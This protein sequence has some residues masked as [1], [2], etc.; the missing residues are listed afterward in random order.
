M[1]QISRSNRAE[2]FIAE[3][4]KEYGARSDF[5][6]GQKLTVKEVK[7]DSRAGAGEE[8]CEYLIVEDE[9]GELHEVEV[10]GIFFDPENHAPDDI[11]DQLVRALGLSAKEAR[12]RITKADLL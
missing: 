11:V 10:P 7:L 1:G 3:F 12:R 2:R 6:P 4:A 9:R 8:V 5:R